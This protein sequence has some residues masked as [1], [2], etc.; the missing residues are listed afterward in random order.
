VGKRWSREATT[1]AQGLDGATAVGLRLR[2]DCSGERVP[3]ETNRE[4][5]H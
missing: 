3:D 1:E 5:A 2:E 4:R